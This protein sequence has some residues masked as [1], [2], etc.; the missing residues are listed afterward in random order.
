[1][2]WLVLHYFP[3]TRS[4]IGP[5][6]W[7]CARLCRCSPSSTSAGLTS[8]NPGLFQLHSWL[9][10]QYSLYCAHPA[11]SGPR[12]YICQ[13]NLCWNA[14][15]PRL[16]Q[17]N[18]HTPLH[19]YSLLR[20]LRRLKLFQSLKSS[21]SCLCRGQPYHNGLRP[22]LLCRISQSRKN[23]PDAPFERTLSF[24]P[25][26][27][28]ATHLRFLELLLC[29]LLIKRERILLLN[30]TYPISSSRGRIS[31][32][33]FPQNISLNAATLLKGPWSLIKSP[34]VHRL[35]KSKNGG[36]WTFFLLNK[37]S[38]LFTLSLILNES[39]SGF[40]A[41]F[42]LWWSPTLLALCSLFPWLHFSSLCRPS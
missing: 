34:E 37:S 12:L 2:W 22:T 3:G 9:I 19:I 21:R 5:L 15:T 35:T 36:S 38:A 14:L 26:P 31:T 20:F 1:M 29:P 42:S 10:K 16:T 4:C 33:E 23:R 41:F 39:P 6:R 8:R 27:I 28:K 11:Q 30:C 13:E 32:F 17:A 25:P 18:W 24:G 7:W 40:P